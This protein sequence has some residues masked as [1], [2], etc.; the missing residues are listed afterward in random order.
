[1]RMWDLC[2]PRNLNTIEDRSSYLPNISRFH[3]SQ[4]TLKILEKLKTLRESELFTNMWQEY[5]SKNV[6]P[7]EGPDTS[8]DDDS[9]YHEGGVTEE[10]VCVEDFSQEAEEEIEPQEEEEEYVDDHGA[11]GDGSDYNK[12]VGD[13]VNFVWK[14][15][16]QK[17]TQLKMSLMD[18]RITVERTKSLFD[19]FQGDYKTT[20]LELELILEDRGKAKQRLEQIK[21]LA[22]VDATMN[23]AKVILKAKKEFKIEGDF[24]DLV[25]L[26]DLVRFIYVFLNLNTVNSEQ[27]FTFGIIINTSVF[28]GT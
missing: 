9:S 1:M 23:G 4:E 16:M 3:F 15:F 27:M 7:E 18:G 12:I 20:G 14:P 17:W 13:V 25:T 11:D 6:F 5:A 26:E 24:S 28:P 8:D 2:E 22:Q 21:L 10:G 19:R